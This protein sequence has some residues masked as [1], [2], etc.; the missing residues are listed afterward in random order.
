MPWW[1]YVLVFFPWL[2]LGWAAGYVVRAFWQRPELPKP[3]P[4]VPHDT[5]EKLKS[6]QRRRI[7]R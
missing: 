4:T 2:L 3:A 7:K 6:I 5:Y 1:A